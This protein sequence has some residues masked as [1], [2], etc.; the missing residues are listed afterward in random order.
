MT[1]LFLKQMF[2]SLLISTYSL[3]QSSGWFAPL[4][5]T[6]PWLE[7]LSGGSPSKTLED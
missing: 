1:L 6:P 3:T 2:I 7:S 5:S 4:P